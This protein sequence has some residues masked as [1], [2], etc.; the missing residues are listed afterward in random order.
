MVSKASSQ[1]D[2]VNDGGGDD[3]GVVRVLVCQQRLQAGDDMS[4]ISPDG[5]ELQETDDRMLSDRTWETERDG[6]T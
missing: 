1:C 5:Q 2:A 4:T 3:S 6:A